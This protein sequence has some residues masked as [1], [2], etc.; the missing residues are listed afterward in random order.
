MYFTALLASVLSFSPGAHAPG[1]CG[2][3][4]VPQK[5]RLGAV[6]SLPTSSP[7]AAVCVP[8]CLQLGSPNCAGPGVSSS[9]G[10]SEPSRLCVLAVWP[11]ETAGI[12]LTP[13]PGCFLLKITGCLHSHTAVAKR[14][15]I[16]DSLSLNYILGEL[17]LL[18]PPVFFSP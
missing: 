4:R 17:L 2:S 6:L 13:L 15:A 14:L 16:I 9:C 7:P 12:L 10:S 5:G 1:S 18:G 3:S 11:S 8:S